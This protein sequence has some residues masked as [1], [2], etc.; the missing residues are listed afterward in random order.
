MTTT[1]TKEFKPVKKASPFSSDPHNN[2]G[3]K[4][5]KKGGAVIAGNAG[6]KGSKSLN[7]TK[8]KGGSGGDR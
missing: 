7:V 3:G 5:G 8:F 4:G 6:F 1:T 2:R